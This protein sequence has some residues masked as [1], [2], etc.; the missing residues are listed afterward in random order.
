VLKDYVADPA[1]VAHASNKFGR[2]RTRILDATARLLS[3][4]GYAATSVSGIAAAAQLKAGSLYYYFDSKDELI[5]EVLR[6]G[7]ARSF[8]HVRHALA[9]LE[10][11]AGA[12]LRLR[13]AMQA[14]LESLDSQGHYSIAGLRILEQAPETIRR[15]QYANQRAYGEFWHELLSAAQGTGV[16]DADL[17]PVTVRLVVFGAMNSVIDWP[18][19]VRKR[20]EEVAE[21]ML[22][23]IQRGCP[24]PDHLR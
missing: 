6:L 17:D 9:G 21:T 4:G 18:R 1:A 13:V 11:G 14:H 7:T 16:I 10:P 23:L 8:D 20:A 12:A 19:P 22:R 15:R 3:E 5:Y 2:T 24:H